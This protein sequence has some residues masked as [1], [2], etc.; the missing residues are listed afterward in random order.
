M[1]TPSVAEP[2][3][4]AEC[5]T[6]IREGEDCERTEG[7][8]FCRGCY[9]RLMYELRQ[10]AAAMGTNVNWPLAAAGGLIGAAGGALVWWGFTI[11][12]GIAFG[13]VAIVIGFA[14]GKGVVLA[15]GGKRH[16]GLQI[17]SAAIAT[18]SFF[19]ASYLVDRTFILEAAA[20]D[21][22]PLMIPL[23]PA[24]DLF[25]AV[26][27]AGFDA[28]DLVFLAIVLYEAWKIPSPAALRAV[29]R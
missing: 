11:A 12:T 14:A 19:Y 9:E 15:S 3:R 1:T 29:A 28:M 4:C 27:G 20:E 23:L 21:G 13:L 17:L 5:S 25:V 26:I 2:V 16:V 18:L 7:G 22:S 8:T 6:V 24:S 10:A